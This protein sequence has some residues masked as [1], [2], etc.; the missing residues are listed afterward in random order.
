MRRRLLI[1]IGL[2]GV[3]VAAL[4][5]LLSSR[6]EP[7]N[8]TCPAPSGS[9]LPV[10]TI[11]P[12][13]VVLVHHDG[14]TRARAR[15]ARAGAALAD[16][17]VDDAL[18]LPPEEL[19]RAREALRDALDVDPRSVRALRAL[20]TIRL[21]DEAYDEAGELAARCL[22][23][24][25]DEVECKNVQLMARSRAG[26]QD[27]EEIERCYRERPNDFVCV[28]S[29]ANL[30]IRE[31]RFD[32]AR[33][34]VMEMRRLEPGDDTLALTYEASIAEMQGDLAAAQRSYEN[35]CRKGQEFACKRAAALAQ[36][37]R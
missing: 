11:E 3:A 32:E 8:P 15:D 30:R 25:P 1:T 35:A 22:A 14:A 12:P 33:R 4:L 21:E 34:L 5:G 7:K 24:T 27:P 20:A 19:G 18:S 2:A 36:R 17:L 13:L 23:L 16:Q 31:R 28:A 26:K 10:A 29:L 37:D 9:S 6:I